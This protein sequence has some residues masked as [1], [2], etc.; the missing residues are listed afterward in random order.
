MNDF[1]M[2]RMA[3]ERQE[4]DGRQAEH[5]RLVA[6]L[7]SAAMPTRPEERRTAVPAGDPVSTRRRFR[8]L[9]RRVNPRGVLHGHPL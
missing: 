3:R 4:E 8:A 9:V 2:L 7:R 1:V 5:D 6:E